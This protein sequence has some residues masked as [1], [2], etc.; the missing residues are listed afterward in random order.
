MVV[1]ILCC[2]LLLLLLL[3]VVVFVFV[4]VWCCVSLFLG[5]VLQRLFLG[6]VDRRERA[7]MAMSKHSAQGL[8]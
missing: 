7:K 6:E 5:K 4:V 3:V 8:K 2:C 1:L